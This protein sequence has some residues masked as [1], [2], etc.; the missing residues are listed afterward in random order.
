MKIEIRNNPKHRNYVKSSPK[1]KH[2]GLA[3]DINHLKDVLSET[4]HKKN[5]HNN[6]HHHK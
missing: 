2:F 1:I 5:S 4:K 6:N 3:F